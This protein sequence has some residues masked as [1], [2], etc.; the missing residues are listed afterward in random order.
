MKKVKLLK[1]SPLFAMARSKARQ[2]DIEPG[3]QKMVELIHAVQLKEG[4][5]SC[6]RKNETCSELDCCWQLSC[7]AE[8][9][10]E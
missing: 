6:F 5:Q 7:S 2:H 9:V 8:M 3:N 4:H 10:R 1:G